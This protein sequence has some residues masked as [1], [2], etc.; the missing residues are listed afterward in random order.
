LR[1]LALLFTLLL[2]VA[3]AWLVWHNVPGLRAP[4]ISGKPQIEKR[5]AVIA[6]RTFDPQ[7]P[8]PEMPPLGPGELAVCDSNFGA[9]ALVSGQS[10]RSDS[11]HAN[12]TVTSVRVILQLSVTMWTP[13]G[14]TQHV[15]NHEEGHRE[16]SEYFYK[17][18]D[19]LAG[20]IAARYLG[21]Q[22]SVS[23]ANLNAEINQ[24][25]LQMGQDITAEF[26]KELNVEAAQLKYD[27]ITD[28]G[29]NDIDFKDAVAEAIRETP[30]NPAQAMPAK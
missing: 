14:V 30:E 16:I 28:H 3:L 25:L 17:T 13:E 8:P 12:V 24:S 9:N 23:G 22:F 20:Q 15:I 27:D 6:S 5:P 11:T 10:R 19:Q 1:R 29:R 26:D 21:K 2:V 4:V 18:A 7:S